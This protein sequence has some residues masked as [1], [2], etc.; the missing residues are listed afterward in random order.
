MN[1]T[2]R[3]Q[4]LSDVSRGMLVAGL[5]ASLA[6]DLGFSTAFAEEG[7]ESI[8]LGD[9][10]SLVDLLESTPAD[11]LQPVL[12]D[13]IKSGRTDL[14]TMIAA[15]SVANAQTFGGCDYVGFHTA[16]AMLPALEMPRSLPSER[17]PLPVFKVL[18][19]NSQQI[20]ALGGASKKTLLALH[21]AEHSHDGDLGVA[22][23]DA[24]RKSDVDR[25]EALFAKVGDSPKDAL[26]ALQP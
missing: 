8:S 19:R 21:A 13:Q 9:Y 25:A 26:N 11:K 2:N 10:A 18:Y 16:M 15:G 22:I 5:G 4:F 20:Q 24:C 12:A 17:Q 7:A 14:R 23:R 1:P 3:R 6:R